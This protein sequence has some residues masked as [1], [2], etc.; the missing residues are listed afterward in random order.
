[1]SQSAQS[2]CIHRLDGAAASSV[3]AIIERFAPAFWERYG[4]RITVDQRKALQA[5]LQCRTPALGG[6]RYDCECGHQHFAHHSCNHRLCPRCGAGDTQEWIQK[7]LG[8]LLPAPYYMVTFTLPEALRASMRGNRPA[9]ECFMRASAQA[10]AELLADPKKR[11]GF[12]RSGFFGVFQTWTQDM[13]WHPHMHYIVPAVGL[14]QQWRLKRPQ[15]PK[16]LLHAQPLAHRLRTLLANALRDNE[17]IDKD[18]FWKIVKIDWNA[19]VDRAGSGENAVKYLGQYV[20]RSVISDQRIIALEGDQ[21][22]IR[23][24]DRDTQ[25]YGSVLID[26]VEF[27]RRFLQ[28]A[29]PPGFHRIRYRGFL[30]ARG[31]KAL[32]W[33]QLLLDARLN[34]K[35]NCERKAPTQMHCPRCGAPMQRTRQMTRAPPHLRNEHFFSAIAA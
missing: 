29:L 11:C 9:M 25:Q 16:F 2:G 7:Q 17:L 19:S 15:N 31:K 5:I 34:P 6:H 20:A 12:H 13:R 21:V 27:V 30:H 35:P 4:E 24:K 1:M 23:I 10:L 14:D 18:T 3:A 32:Q 33:L 26:G 28:H 8:K 22:R